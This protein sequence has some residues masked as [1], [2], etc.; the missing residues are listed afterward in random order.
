M[1][2]RCGILR[3]FAVAVAAL[4]VFACEQGPPEFQEA[5]VLGGVT[6]S[7]ETLNHGRKLYLRSCASCHGYDGSGNGPAARTMN[8]GPRDFRNEEFLYT[9]T[10]EGALP[11][12]DDLAKTIREGRLDRGMPSWKGM[13]KADIDALVQYIKT[14]S[15]RW[16][17]SSAPAAGG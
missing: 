16:R 15:P 8:P 4:G 17:D 3:G 11:S 14:F 5:Q 13:H 12:D 6:V 7:A 9:S 1:R 2:R 10:P